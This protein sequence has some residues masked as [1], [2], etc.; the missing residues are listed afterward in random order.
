MFATLVML[1]SGI[2]HLVQFE[3]DQLINSA[4]EQSPP[5]VSERQEPSTG[6]SQPKY[7]HYT[8]RV[9]TITVCIDVANI[10]FCQLILSLLNRSLDSKK[11][12][13]IGN[14][15]VR[16][17]PRA[18]GIVALSVVWIPEYNDPSEP[19]GVVLFIIFMVVMW[20]YVAGMDRH[21]KLFE[22]KDAYS[23]TPSVSAQSEGP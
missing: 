3:Q 1:S 14:Q 11:D 9:A 2:L 20:E 13:L 22:P 5:A 15:W 21:S 17:I 23:L 12:L 8:F 10:M 18:L 4:S 16:M 19:L 6:S 7:D